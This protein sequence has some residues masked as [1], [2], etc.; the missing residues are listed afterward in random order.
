MS[1][2]VKVMLLSCVTIIAC[3]IMITAG[4]LALFSGSVEVKNHLQAGNLKVTLVRTAHSNKLLD[5]NGFLA[6]DEV[7]NESVD[8][9]GSNNENV[10]GLASGALVVPGSE[11]SATFKI[12]N[13]GKVAFGY[14]LDLTLKDENGNP[15]DTA[16]ANDLAKQLKIELVVNGTSVGADKHLS[17]GQLSIGSA[18]QNN[19]V[20]VG[21]NNDFTIKI[22]FEDKPNGENNPAQDKSVYFDI[23]VNAI[24]V[25]VNPNP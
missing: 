11:L 1:K 20:A 16:A 23:V 12:T 8:F 7:T 21:Q 14:W 17:E 9:A 25:N 4:T 3:L 5:A 24:Q 10:F 13:A 15:V 22:T 18:T 19:V 2:G 6:T